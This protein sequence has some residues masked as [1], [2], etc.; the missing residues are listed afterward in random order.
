ME[1][2]IFVR[3]GETS[4]NVKDVM[5]NSD[6]TELLTS[7]GVDQIEK[8]A[9]KLKEYSPSRVYSSKE[10]R[11]IQSGELIAGKL[12]IEL[13][14][15]DGMQERNWGEL[16]NKP[17]SEVQKILD[18]M[19]LEERYEYIPPGGESWRQFEGRLIKAVSS[20]IE[21]SKDETIVIVTHGGAIRALMPYLLGAP[22]EESFKHSPDNASIT[23][24]NQNNGALIQEIVNDTAHL[25]PKS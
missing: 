15:I 24:F 16:S 4:K 12:S 17:W 14:P 8:T 19:S 7:A 9:E 21:N 13:E 11:A 18:P 23:V 3:H 1:R 6:D 25:Q 10:A 5:H 2:F 20:I 22:K